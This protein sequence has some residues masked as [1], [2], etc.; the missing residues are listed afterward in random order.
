VNHIC[1]IVN[2][3]LAATPQCG[4]TATTGGTGLVTQCLQPVPGLG[5]IGVR[6]QLEPCGDP[7]FAE[8]SYQ[9]GS[10][11]TSADRIQAGGSPLLFPIP[12]AALP[13][14]LSGAGLFISL[15]VVG[16]AADLSVHA[17]LSAC[18][19]GAC[20]GEVPLV[21]SLLTATGFPFSLLEFDDLG[22]VDSCPA[23]ESDNMMLM[24]A[25]GGG[26]IFLIGGGVLA[27]IAQK[28]KANSA[29]KTSTPVTDTVEMSSA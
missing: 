12:G 17:R 22:F 23:D 13:A 15:T 25:A 1:D 19:N 20:D 26:A 6:I 21:G 29:P 27:F 2:P 9:F 28:K 24:I 18:L 11:W 3:F 14:Y 10:S 8:T 5:N 7:A 16:N 4:C